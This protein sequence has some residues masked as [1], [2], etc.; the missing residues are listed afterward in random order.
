MCTAQ[1]LLRSTAH[2]LSMV[3]LW[4]I[5][6]FLC[7][8]EPWIYFILM[9]SQLLSVNA[10]HVLQSTLKLRLYFA[11]GLHLL[12]LSFTIVPYLFCFFIFLLHCQFLIAPQQFLM[13][14]LFGTLPQIRLYSPKSA[15][16]PNVQA[17]ADDDCSKETGLDS[18]LRIFIPK[19]EFL[20]ARRGQLSL[21]SESYS[22]GQSFLR[23]HFAVGSA[24]WSF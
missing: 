16:G 19:N 13:L 22:I 21:C 1:N 5:Y 24:F 10:I 8:S 14:P 15:I 20:F 6:G 11:F 12:V 7:I 4:S 17:F 2:G 23:V 18:C 9:L 3:Y